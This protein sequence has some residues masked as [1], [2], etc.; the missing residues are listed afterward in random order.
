MD[1]LTWLGLDWDEGPQVGGPYGPYVQSERGEIYTEVTAK[2]LESGLA[3][4]CYC[5]REELEARETAAAQGRAVRVRRALPGPDCRA[6]G[7]VRGRGRTFVVRMRVPDAP[8]VFHDL[9]RGEVR[10]EAVERAR[11]RARP[12]HRGAAL[13]PGQPRRRRADGDHPRAPGRG[14][15][16]LDAAAG[17]ALPGARADR[18]GQRSSADL[19]SPADRAG[20]GQPPTVQAGQGIRSGRVPRAGLSARGAA[21]LPGPAGLGDR[22]R[23]RRLHHRGDGGRRST[24]C[25]STPTRPSSTPRSARRSTPRTS[26]GCPPTSWPSSWCR[27]WSRPTWWPIRRLR[28]SGRCWSAPPR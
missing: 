1:A 16:A 6:G 23:P 13:H 25:G 12:G 18:R 24:S 22:R 20:R 21:Q 10:F 3:Y 28:S 2:L 11:L 26:G 9:V 14:P 7:C 17:G 8:I 4:R 5:T 27:S 19:R 15:A